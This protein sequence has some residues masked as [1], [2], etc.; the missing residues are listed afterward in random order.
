MVEEE[1][2]KGVNEET[3]KRVKSALYRG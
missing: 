3:T 1:K 2:R